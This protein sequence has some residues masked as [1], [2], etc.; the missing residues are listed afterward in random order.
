MRRGDPW[1]SHPGGHEASS[2]I[3]CS[4]SW[5]ADEG[6][7]DA[8]KRLLCCGART[9]G[10]RG[11]Q[12][13]QTFMPQSVADAS[14]KSACTDAVL[15]AQIPFTCISELVTWHFGKYALWCSTMLRSEHFEIQ[16]LQSKIASQLTF[17][18]CAALRGI[19]Q[20]PL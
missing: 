4:S 17:C 1:K 20:L 14:G 11:V 3:C 18:R 6:D 16:T 10:I 2:Q 12:G 7:K 8:D 15:S 9:V 13:A 5:Q 19:M